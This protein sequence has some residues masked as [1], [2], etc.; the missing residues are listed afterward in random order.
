MDAKRRF[1]GLRRCA[2]SVLALPVKMKN[3]GWTRQTNGHG[4]RGLRIP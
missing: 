4:S 2:E 3:I 1:Q